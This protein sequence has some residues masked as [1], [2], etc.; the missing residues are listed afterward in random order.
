MW[1]QDVAFWVL[2]IVVIVA[3]LGVVLVRD[4]FVRRCFWRWC[5]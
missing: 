2:A 3:A 5:S 4:F 1:F